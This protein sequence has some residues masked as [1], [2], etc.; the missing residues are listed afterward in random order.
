MNN[1]LT[2]AALE[3]LK[4]KGFRYVIVSGYAHDNRPDYME[5]HYFVLEPVSSCRKM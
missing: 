2:P 1:E 4:K 3:E 5:A